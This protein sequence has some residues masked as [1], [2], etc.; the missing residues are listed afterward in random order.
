MVNIFSSKFKVM[1][2]GALIVALLV[3]G[4]FAV[5]SIVSGYGNDNAPASIYEVANNSSATSL[6]TNIGY[7][8]ANGDEFG[9]WY[10]ARREDS[11]MI[12]TYEYDRFH[13]LEESIATGET[14]RIVAEEGVVYYLNGKYYNDDDADKTPWVGSPMDVSFSFKL[15]KSKLSTIITP[16][17]NLLYATVTAENYKAMF[18]VEL[19]VDGV[20]TMS[21]ESNGVQVTA[22]QISYTTT[23]GA[24]VTSYTTYSYNDIT[25]DFTPVTGEEETEAE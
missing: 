24:K 5:F 13:T 17:P 16:N 1:L 6:T 22:V 23:S 8:T 20:I 19:D 12:I 9:G 18:G 14:G 2:I 15:D 10:V 7:V 4:G 21:V 25:L 11:N 3:G